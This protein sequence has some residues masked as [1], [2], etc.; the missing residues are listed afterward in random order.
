MDGYAELAGARIYYRDTGG[1]GAAVVFLHPGSGNSLVFEKQIDPFVARG[2]RVIAFDRAGQGRSVRREGASD[3][4]APD[5]EQLMDYLRIERFHL[6]GVAAGGGVALQYVLRRPERVLSLVV[7]NSIGNVQDAAYLAISRRLRPPS[8]DQLPLEMREL[9]PSYRALNPE[10]VQRW[11]EI[12]RTPATA[13][14]RNENIRPNPSSSRPLHEILGPKPGGAPTNHSDT[15]RPPGGPRGGGDV[16]VTFAALKKMTV[17]TLLLTG[18][19]DPYMPPSVLRLFKQ[20]MPSAE[21]CV[22]P[23]SGHAAHWENPE[24]FNRH[25]LEFLAKH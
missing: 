20:H 17:P 18:D 13:E 2:Y 15:P 9:G 4:A 14:P 23:E 25:V 19:A 22:I 24:E 11:V 3:P 10:G 8:F 16:Q 7:A 1:S 5:L 12:S 21:M 6:V